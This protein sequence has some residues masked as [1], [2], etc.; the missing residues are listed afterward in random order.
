LLTT[1]LKRVACAT[2]F[3][4]YTLE[5]FEWLGPAPIKETAYKWPTREH[6]IYLRSQKILE[7]WLKSKEAIAYLKTNQVGITEGAL[8][9]K[10]LS[11]TIQKRKHTIGNLYKISSLDNYAILYKQKQLHNSVR[12]SPQHWFTE[13]QALIF[14]KERGC[15]L[16]AK[17]LSSSRSTPF[18]ITKQ[19]ERQV[20]YLANSI[21]F[22]FIEKH[23]TFP[24]DT[25]RWL[26]S[27]ETL[28]YFLTLGFT[29]SPVTLTG[30]RAKKVFN[31]KLD[32]KGNFLFSEKSI[33][34]FIKSAS[35][36]LL[37]KS[38]TDFAALKEEGW[39]TRKESLQ[40]LISMGIPRSRDSLTRWVRKG[41]IQGKTIGHRVIINQKSLDKHA[42]TI[43]NISLNAN[44]NDA[45]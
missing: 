13:T 21:V 22:L 33:I 3:S 20:L 31:C 10:A 30:W 23:S 35:P 45:K 28:K 36:D 29:V 6:K 41:K 16:K 2:I 15:T 17:E 19:Q 5:F 9:R 12:K 37:I 39:I 34:K 32:K 1:G 43:V 7:G 18:M 25:G 26:R 24:K 8:I 14:A 11:G 38:S 27:K 4:Q 42:Q 40:Q 44:L